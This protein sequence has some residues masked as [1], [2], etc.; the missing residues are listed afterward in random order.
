[1]LYLSGISQSLVQTAAKDAFVIITYRFLQMYIVVP[2]VLQRTHRALLRLFSRIAGL[3][4]E[5]E[6]GFQPILEGVGRATPSISGLL[7]P[8]ANLSPLPSR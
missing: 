4:T 5:L 2:P 3:L 1:M 6:V 7:I 8:C